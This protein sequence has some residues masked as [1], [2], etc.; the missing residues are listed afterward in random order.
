MNTIRKTL[1]FTLALA[2]ALFSTAFIVQAQTQTPSASSTPMTT[3]SPGAP[4]TGF[5]GV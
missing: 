3:I 2:F 4:N 1:L 5:E